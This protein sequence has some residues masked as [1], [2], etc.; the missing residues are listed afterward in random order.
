MAMTVSVTKAPAIARPPFG[1]PTPRPASGVSTV[2]LDPKAGA[3]CGA[4][5]ND[6]L[7]GATPTYDR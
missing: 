4:G 6:L 7:Q 5:E 3:P 1:R 2:E